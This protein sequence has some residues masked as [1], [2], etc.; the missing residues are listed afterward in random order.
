MNGNHGNIEQRLST[1]RTHCRHGPGGLGGIPFEGLESDGSGSD[2]N[3]VWRQLR[4]GKRGSGGLFPLDVSG[5]LVKTR[6]RT[7]HLLHG[8]PFLFELNLAM[9]NCMVEKAWSK[10]KSGQTLFSDYRGSDESLR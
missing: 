2:K 9:I 1:V 3:D 5:N 7:E 8:A 10:R 4:Y 6:L